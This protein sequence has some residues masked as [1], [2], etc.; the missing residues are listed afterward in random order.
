MDEVVLGLLVASSAAGVATIIVDFFR[1][2]LS[3]PRSR[4]T[5]TD[6]EGNEL[7]LSSKI[8]EQEFEREVAGAL[9]AGRTPRPEESKQPE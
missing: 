8:G 7:I 9:G 2:R 6:S 5:I 1:N 4:L 3:K